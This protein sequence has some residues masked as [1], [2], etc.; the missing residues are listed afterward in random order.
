MARGRHIRRIPTVAWVGVR[1]L[2]RYSRTLD[3]YVLRVIG[4][5]WGPILRPPGR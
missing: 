4:R 2:F 1:P 5:R 3:A